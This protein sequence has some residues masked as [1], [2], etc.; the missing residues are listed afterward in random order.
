M[1]VSSDHPQWRPH[2][3]ESQNGIARETATRPEG[4]HGR[5]DHVESVRAASPTA[6]LQS[7]HLLLSRKLAAVKARG[8]ER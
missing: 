3:D 7:P 8:G 4:A 2:T 1:G 6:R 5:K